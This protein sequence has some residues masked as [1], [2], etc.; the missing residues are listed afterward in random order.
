M[1]IFQNTKEG[2]LKSKIWSGSSWGSTIPIDTNVELSMFT[3]AEYAGSFSATQDPTGTIYITYV[4]NQNDTNYTNDE[5]RTKFFAGAAWV[6]GQNVALPTSTYGGVTDV[7]LA[8]GTT[9]SRL[10]VAFSTRTQLPTVNP[11]E[12][13]AENSAKVYY[14]TH[15]AGDI[16]SGSWSPPI[17][18][19]GTATYNWRGLSLNFQSF[20]RMYLVAVAINATAVDAPATSYG[21]TIS[22]SP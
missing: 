10:Y 6:T 18:A 5:I 1:A 16:T 13:A 17:L 8:Y 4:A 2:I 20:N 9:H 3:N 7:S 21:T 19:L 15:T 14:A 11:P 22:V 12:V